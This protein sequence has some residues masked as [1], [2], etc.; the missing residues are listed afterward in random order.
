MYKNAQ[1]GGITV[2]PERHVCAQKYTFELN[3]VPNIE[4]TFTAAHR[5]NGTSNNRG[6]LHWLSDL[7]C[8]RTYI[9]P[10]SLAIT[11]HLPNPTHDNQINWQLKFKTNKS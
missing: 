6:A 8:T 10:L 11:T 4:N 7:L 3:A 2:M 5:R 1:I 9:S